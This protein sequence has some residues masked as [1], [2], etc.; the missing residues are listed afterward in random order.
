MEG[1]D[2][3]KLNKINKQC[4]LTVGITL[5]IDTGYSE[6]KVATTPQDL[7]G[8]LKGPWLHRTVK[9]MCLLM[10]ILM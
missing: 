5:K 6:C 1:P 8:N 10:F 9:I 3:L 4:S 2:V 7:K